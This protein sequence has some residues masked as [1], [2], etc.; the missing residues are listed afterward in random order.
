MAFDLAAAIHH[1]LVG[2]TADPVIHYQGRWYDRAW[3][4]DAVRRLDEWLEGT[5]RVALAARNRPLHVA[6]CLADL[7]SARTTAMVTVGRGAEA[8]SESIRM[9]RPDVLIAER[10]DWT[11]AALATA[12]ELGCGAVATDDDGELALLHPAGASGGPVSGDIALELLSSGTTGLP[13]RIGLSWQA[14]A[15]AVATARVAYTGTSAGGAQVMVHPLGNISGLAYAVPPLVYGQSLVLLDR[16]RAES[17]AAAVHA[18]HPRRGA[19]PPAGIAM[20]LE[21]DVPSAWLESLDV[22]AVGGGRLDPALHDAFEA[23]FGMAV[24]TAY[25]ATEFGGVVANWTLDAYRDHGQSKRG[26]AGRASAGA[27]LRIVASDGRVCAPGETGLLEASVERIGPGW[28]RTTDLARIDGDGYLFIEGRADSAINRGGFTI[29][30]DVIVAALCRHP[31]IRDAAVIGMTDARLGE[32]PMAAVE[33]VAGEQ[34]DAAGLD[35]WLRERLPPWQ[36]PKAIR[37]VETLPRTATFKVSLPDVRALF[38]DP[39]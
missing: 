16:F 2:A 5:Q 20:L 1:A 27:R 22:V 34:P 38:D 32:V 15:G 28:I 18:H 33:P 37:I 21:S 9:L 3:L 4:A 8:L 35:D 29:V 39:R 6:A 17:W 13:K 11:A 7:K 26:S 25:G 19:V 36:V 30:P 14:V 24:L 31:Q 10:Q 23:R 12:A